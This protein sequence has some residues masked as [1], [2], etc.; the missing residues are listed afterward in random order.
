MAQGVRK[1]IIIKEQSAKGTAGSGAGA[2][3]LRRRTANFNKV[4]DTYTN[5]EIT[6][7]RQSTGAT[8]GIGRYPGRYS[9]LMSPATHALIYAQALRRDFTAPISAVTGL[10]LVT[11][12][13]GALYTITRTGGSFLTDG[14]K[15]GD[16]G[17]I[18][19]GS[20]PADVLN[21]RLVVLGVTATVLTVRPLNGLALQTHG[22]VATCTWATIGKKTFAPT[23]GHTDKWQTWEEFYPDVPASE[24]YVDVKAAT[25]TF[26]LPA[27]GNVTLDVDLQALSRTKGTASVFTSPATATTTGVVQGAM[28]AVVVNGALQPITGGTITLATGYSQGEAETGSNA[29][30]DMNE[31]KISVSGEIRAKFTSTAL[32]AIFDAQTVTSLIVA[33]PT[34]ASPAPE[35]IVIAIPV[36]HLF[37]DAADDGEKEIIRTYQ[38]TAEIPNPTV[39]GAGLPH[40]QTIVQIVDSG[41]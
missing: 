6:D 1:Q 41:A 30:T 15:I 4:V 2:Q 29:V 36:I 12:A 19:A 16:V 10:S 7:H 23:S 26:G 34:D 18:S 5:D 32:S 11:A 39:G 25:L 37:G 31:G 28:M 20:V 38:F 27:T 40:N 24:Q 14:V 17:A 13:A 8:A 22:S 9:G 3:I 35:F 21:R 33:L